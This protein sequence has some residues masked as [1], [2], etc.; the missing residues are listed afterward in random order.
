MQQQ[1]LKEWGVKSVGLKD[2]LQHGSK[3]RPKAKGFGKEF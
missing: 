3:G 2:S 1:I